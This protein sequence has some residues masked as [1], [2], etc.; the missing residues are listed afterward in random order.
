MMDK[1]ILSDIPVRMMKSFNK[2]VSLSENL[3][4]DGSVNWNFVDADVYADMHAFG[5]TD[6]GKLHYEWFD[7]LADA[8]EQAN[9]VNT[10]EWSVF[11]RDTSYTRSRSLLDKEVVEINMDMMAHLANSK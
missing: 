1:V 5:E 8:Y 6:C 10:T 11:D 7:L 4:P 9:G 3:L 2:A